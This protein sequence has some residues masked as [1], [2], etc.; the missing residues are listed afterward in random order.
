MVVA[1]QI[2]KINVVA[3]F[4]LQIFIETSSTTTALRMSKIPVVAEFT[5][6]IFVEQA[7]PPR[8]EKIMYET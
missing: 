4:T 3:E 8:Y 5:L 1:E 6:Q 2:S 7:R